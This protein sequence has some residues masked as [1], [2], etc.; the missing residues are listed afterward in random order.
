MAGLI[1]QKDNTRFYISNKD[2]LTANDKVHNVASI[3]DIASDTEDVDVSTLESIAREYES[4]FESNGNIDLTLNLTSE[5]YVTM[6]NYK[7]DGTNIKWGLAVLNKAKTDTIVGLSG[8]GQVKSVTLTGL[9]VG[10]VIQVNASIR[11]SG[12]IDNKFKAPTTEGE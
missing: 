4:G 11:V 7:N 12:D 2:N 1:A 5:E 6:D 8:G 10:G 3:G 9:T